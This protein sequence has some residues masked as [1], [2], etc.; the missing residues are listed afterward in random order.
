M[1]LAIVQ[2]ATMADK[3]KEPATDPA[4][5]PAKKKSSKGKFIVILGVLVL[6]LGGG[7]AAA[8]FAFRKPAASAT[9]DAAP[10]K[11]TKPPTGI[12]SFEPFVVN[13]ADPGA[14]HFLRINVRLIVADEE[15]A[16]KIEESQVQL[17]RL[18][19]TVVDLLTSETSEHIVSADGKTALK[20]EIA[21]RA[22]KIVEPIEVADVLF[23]DFVVQY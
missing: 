5:S 10:K 23:S 4:A 9:G 18:R 6:L 16:K 1:S 7:G 13:L 20:K 21:E 8:F 17:M 15:E 12:I 19:S 14:Q 22:A 2:P 3:D 11:E